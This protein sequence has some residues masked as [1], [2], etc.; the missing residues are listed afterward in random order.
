MLRGELAVRL[1]RVHTLLVRVDVD[2]LVELV[3]LVVG[4]LVRGL[5]RLQ[6]RH[7]GRGHGVLRRGEVVWIVQT[8]VLRVGLRLVEHDHGDVI[9]S[10]SRVLFLLLLHLQERLE[11]TPLQVHFLLLHLFSS[12]EYR[13]NRSHLCWCSFGCSWRRLMKKLGLRLLHQLLLCIGIVKVLLMLAQE[14][15]QRWILNNR[16]DIFLSLTTG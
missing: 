3:A 15:L 9:H 10:V 4:R 13:I 14:R 7:D 6:F 11:A 16:G 2:V 1:R 8:D 12:A 5:G